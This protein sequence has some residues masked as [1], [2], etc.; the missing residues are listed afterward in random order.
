MD[1]PYLLGTF[2][3][4]LWVFSKNVPIIW[5]KWT[6]HKVSQCPSSW[7]SYYMLH[8]MFSVCRITGQLINSKKYLHFITFPSKFFLGYSLCLYF[9]RTSKNN[10]QRT[11][12]SLYKLPPTQNV[13]VIFLLSLY[14]T[15]PFKTQNQKH[16]WKDG[17]KT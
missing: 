11:C 17:H 3:L 6:L 5:N 7:F 8:L 1:R 4:L 13:F 14:Q 16:S 12:S 9:L 2:R 10:F 15:A